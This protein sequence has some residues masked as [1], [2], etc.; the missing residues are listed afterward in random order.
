M[1]AAAKWSALS[2]PA[3]RLILLIA[4][5]I[6]AFAPFD[7]IF[8]ALTM[9]SPW[10]R[11][12]WIAILIWIGVT[13]GAKLGLRLPGHCAASWVRIGVVAAALM[14][15]YVI[16]LDCFVFRALLNPNYVAF[17][18]RPLG[19][20]LA[21]FMTRAFN[22]NVIYRLFAFGS[23]AWLLNRGRSAMPSRGILAAAMIGAQLINIGCNVLLSQG[24][25]LTPLT[26]VYDA[27]RYIVPGVIWA[28]LYVR[29]G[30]ATAEVASVGCHVFLQPAF[31]LLL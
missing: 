31:S 14:A 27:L 11:M 25:I 3:A 12:A 10:L 19:E 26:L 21:Y 9:G 29:N 16:L 7:V 2:D 1:N 22:E 23:L 6:A 8:S 24:A 4:L 30:F 28:I 17:L 15:G 18:H 13:A 20:R 5:P